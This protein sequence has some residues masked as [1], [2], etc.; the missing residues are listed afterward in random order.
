MHLTAVRVYYI[1]SNGTSNK[2]TMSQENLHKKIVR[3]IGEHFPANIDKIIFSAGFDSERAFLNLNKDTISEIEQYVNENKHI[4][5]STS[6]ENSCTFKFKPGH[7]TFLLGIPKALEILN[8]KNKSKKKL[9][10]NSQENQNS[11]ETVNPQSVNDE[12]RLNSEVELKQKL[13]DKI[14]KFANKFSVTLIIETANIVNFHQDDT[15]FRCQV[16][17]PVCNSNL[18]CQYTTYWIISNFEHHLKRHFGSNIHTETLDVEIRPVSYTEN[19][20]DLEFE[21]NG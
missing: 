17:C 10:P 14:I 8:K 6:Y 7:K 12:V 4:L 16:I 21:L 15:K 11:G 1:G 20:S 18:K 3:A 9:L 2:R 19:K 5:A 13:I